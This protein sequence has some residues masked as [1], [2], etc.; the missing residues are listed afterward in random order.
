MCSADR[1]ECL[2]NVERVGADQL[3]PVDDDLELDTVLLDDADLFDDCCLLGGCSVKIAG[4]GDSGG[5]RKVIARATSSK[6]M[7]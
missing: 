5:Y 1:T 6:S 2:P 4:A 7:E 3:L